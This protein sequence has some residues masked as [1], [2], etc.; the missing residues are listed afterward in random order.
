MNLI[1]TQLNGISFSYLVSNSK[2]TIFQKFISGKIINSVVDS[3]RKQELLEWKR[4]I[5]KSI[6]ILLNDKSISPDRNH[7]ISLSIQFSPTLHGNAKLDVENYVKPIVDGIAAGLFCSNNQDPLK[8][9]KFDYDDSNFN[10]LFVEKL[11]DCNS[12]DE[13]LIITIAQL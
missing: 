10:K 1:S 3:N 13:G 4:K 5:A 9:D 12:K 6:F 8:I 2:N 7:A 11:D